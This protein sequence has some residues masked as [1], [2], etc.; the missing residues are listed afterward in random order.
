M[1]FDENVTDG[2]RRPAETQPSAGVPGDRPDAPATGGEH[3]DRQRASDLSVLAV[4]TGGVE[5]VE[6]LVG[7]AFG[8]G[9]GG[10]GLLAVIAG[11]VALVRNGGSR[12]DRISAI[13]R[14]RAW[15]GGS[16]H[17]YDV[18]RRPVRDARSVRSRRRGHRGAGR[19]HDL[20]RSSRGPGATR[21]VCD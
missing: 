12:S 10:L 1:S 16:G 17:G 3:P 8:P 15:R 9:Y 18:V 11:I 6:A 13:N 21:R 5:I 14:H 2:V 20:R 7:F 19:G 4:I